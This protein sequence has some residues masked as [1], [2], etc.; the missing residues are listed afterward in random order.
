[1]RKIILLLLSLILILSVIAAYKFSNNLFV[2]YS[3]KIAQTLVNGKKFKGID[4][5]SLDFKTAKFKF[6]DT[7][8]WQ[9]VTSRFSINKKSYLLN[10]NFTLQANRLSLKLADFFQKKF[11][12][13]ASNLTIS[14]STS[15][16][17][18]DALP[19]N[20]TS[21]GIEKGY[22]QVKFV[23]D[24]FRP[25]TAKEQ[26]DQLYRKLS[27]LF[28]DGKTILPVDYSGISFFTINDDPVRARIFTKRD[29]DGYY[30]IHVNKE[31]FK[32]MAWYHMKELTDAEAQLLSENPFKMHELIEIMGYA[33]TKSE[34][35]K[36]MEQIPEDAYRH[37]LWSY[38]LTKKFGEKFAIRVTDAHEKGDHTNTEAEHKMDFNNNTIGREYALS[39]YQKDKILTHLLNDPRVIRKP[40]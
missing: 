8:Y 35:F 36:N 16:K 33:T 24:F 4:I 3:Q 15:I 11:L 18:T 9:D 20:R 13:S 21:E 5:L 37:V 12:I 23:F 28:H 1:M 17:G 6:P 19:V 32:T 38:L 31:I 39:G 22:F 25:G 26:I 29:M 7:I 2:Q 27:N 30:A 14:P 34:K 10:Q 40:E